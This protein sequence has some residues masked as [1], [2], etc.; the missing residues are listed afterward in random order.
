MSR[1]CVVQAGLVRALE[2]RV[3][4][5]GV[6]LLQSEDA[7]TMAHMLALFAAAAPGL[8]LLA[9]VAAA[10]VAATPDGRSTEAGSDPSDPDVGAWWWQ[11][12]TNP[13]GVPSER[14]VY[15][16]DMG[17]AADVLRAM[18]VKRS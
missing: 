9:P 16:R 14:E 4:P 1:R 2:A 17:R 8:Q 13:L 11:L 18:L 10:E 3:A 6:V 7:D 5:N 12:P 15:C